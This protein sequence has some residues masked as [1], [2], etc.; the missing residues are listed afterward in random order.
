MNILAELNYLVL[1]KTRHS[2]SSMSWNVEPLLQTHKVAECHPFWE[3]VLREHH[4]PLPRPPCLE[5][6]MIQIVQPMS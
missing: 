3:E 2:Q 4:D 5:P 6:T 1:T